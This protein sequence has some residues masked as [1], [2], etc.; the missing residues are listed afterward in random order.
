MTLVPHKL[1]VVVVFQLLSR[2]QL[3]A[4]PWTAARQASLSFTI[5]WNVSSPHYL[6]S[7]NWF[8]CSSNT[9]EQPSAFPAWPSLLQIHSHLLSNSSREATPT[10]LFRTETTHT[11]C[12]H[13]VTSFLFYAQIYGFISYYS[14][15]VNTLTIAC[16]LLE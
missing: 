14:F 13:Y 7:P 1:P 9:H 4:T 16:L 15:Y 2:V 10:I 3:F 5:S 6:V 12:W 11:H 8:P